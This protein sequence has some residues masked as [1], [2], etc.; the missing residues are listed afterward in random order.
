MAVSGPVSLAHDAGATL[1]EGPVWDEAR[2]CL[3]FVDIKA[4]A[5]WR[6]DPVSGCARRIEAPDQAGWVLPTREGSL[7]IGLKS[8]L[9]LL[10]LE[11]GGFAN[12]A[13]VPGEPK[14]NR[15]ND[16]CTDAA[17]RVWFGSMDD[18]ENR[19]TGRYYR[20]ERG[21]IVVVGPRRMTITNGP[22]ISGCGRHIYFADTLGKKI[23][24]ADL[25]EG[26]LPGEA[27]LFVDIARDFADAYPDGPVV[28]AEG[29]VWTGLWNGWAVARYS[30][31]GELLET[32]PMPVANITK[33]AFGGEDLRTVFVTTA[34][35]G[36]DEAALEAQPSAGGLFSFRSDVAGTATTPV[37][38]S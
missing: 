6:F 22:A 31:E 32:V 29:C 16:A 4:P 11:S 17:G 5:I 8:G 2:Q 27:R 3:W 26:G 12:V 37:E 20:F 30:P 9:H 25:S 7:L 15:L 38:M 24:C 28:D 21:S 19:E 18:D 33:I 13:E 1:G 23:Y 10:D 35:K 36:L 14:H 34:R